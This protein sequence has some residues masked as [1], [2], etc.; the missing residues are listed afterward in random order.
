MR[1][2]RKY[3]LPLNGEAML[4]QALLLHPEAFHQPYP[5]RRINNIYFDTAARDCYLD[6]Q[7]GISLR[8]KV[9]LRWYG[10]PDGAIDHPVLEE[11]FK[12]NHMGW[13]EIHR[14]PSGLTLDGI[15]TEL[16]D[17]PVIAAAELEPVLNNSYQRSYRVSAD[18][19]F[20]VTIDQQLAFGAYEPQGFS[21]PYP[22]SDRLIVE[23]KYKKKDLDSAEDFARYWPFRAKR[24]SKYSTGLEMV[25]DPA[26]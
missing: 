10:A 1:Y 15:L 13:K 17:N 8:K 4:E 24:F 21:C 6:N 12:R 7:R 19:R 2:E 20:R 22:F 3:V 25:A 23:W 26:I 18:G 14:L 9:R 11:K 16:R 5:D